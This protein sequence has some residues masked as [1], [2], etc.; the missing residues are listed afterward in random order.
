MEEVS[1]AFLTFVFDR[2]GGHIVFGVKEGL[3]PGP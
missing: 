2:V 1:Y 3:C